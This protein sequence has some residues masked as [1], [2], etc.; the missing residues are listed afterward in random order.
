MLEGLRNAR[1]TFYRMAKAAL[2]DQVSRNVLSY[3]DYIV[4]VSKKKEKYLTDF[5]KHVRSQAQVE[6]EKVCVR[7]YKREGPQMSGVNEGYRSKP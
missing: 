3:V 7:D 4:V 2:K 5:R 6:Y 1:P